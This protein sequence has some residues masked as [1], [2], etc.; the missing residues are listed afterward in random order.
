VRT[1]WIGCFLAAFI[2]G[3]TYFGGRSVAGAQEEPSSTTTVAADDVAETTEALRAD[4]ARAQERIE[5]L[6]KRY[7]REH[8]RAERLHRRL[9]PYG[10][11]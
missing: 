2:F 11:T 3:M 1:L 8:R 6:R 4:L 10:E 7:W 5:Q 9:Y